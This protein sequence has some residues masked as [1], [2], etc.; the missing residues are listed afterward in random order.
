MINICKRGLGLDY[1]FFLR[2]SHKRDHSVKA[3]G[4]VNLRSVSVSTNVDG[5][6][7]CAIA[8][9]MIVANWQDYVIG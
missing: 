4:V 9:I 3:L 7:K 2:P 1:Q 5:S 8:I 6:G